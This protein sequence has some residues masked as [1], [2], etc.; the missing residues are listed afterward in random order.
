MAK[1]KFCTKVYTIVITYTHYMYN[2]CE[3]VYIAVSI[4]FHRLCTLTLVYRF[5]IIGHNYIAQMEW[6]RILPH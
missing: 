4:G 1:S 5:Q 6:P 2:N 3:I